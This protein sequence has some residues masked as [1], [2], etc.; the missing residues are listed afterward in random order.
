MSQQT[1]DNL[2]AAA[3]GGALG[4]LFGLGIAAGA[5]GMGYVLG[6]LEGK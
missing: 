4:A 2:K 6:K 3:K 5:Y 1:K